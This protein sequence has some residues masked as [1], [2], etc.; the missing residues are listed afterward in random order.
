MRPM[1]FLLLWRIRKQGR[2]P[3]GFSLVVLDN[4]GNVVV[5]LLLSPATEDC[6]CSMGCREEHLKRCI[7]SVAC[8][9]VPYIPY[10]NLFHI[11]RT[12]TK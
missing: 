3:R 7:F 9:E 12:S 4:R 8:I 2:T 11:S 5:D 6:P 10:I 1:S